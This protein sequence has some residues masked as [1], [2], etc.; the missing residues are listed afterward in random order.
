MKVFLLQDVANL[1]RKNEIKEVSDGFAR[2]F[3]FPK[4]LA[5]PVDQK[6]LNFKKE[7]ERKEK[8][9][10]EMLKNLAQQ[11]ENQSLVF[12]LKVG[13]QNEVFG[14]VTKEQISKALLAAG[15]I[16]DEEKIEVLL[17]KPIKSLGE[18][19]VE[20]NLSQNIRSKIKIVIQPTE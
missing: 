13:S 12:K 16:K 19:R 8:Q 3:L 2:N 11:L 1:G 20:I 14:S 10:L 18:H 6:I 7:L 9:K 4:K 15:L 5:V 17:E